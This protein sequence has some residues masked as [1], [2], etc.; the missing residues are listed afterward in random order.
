MKALL[1][2]LFF[3]LCGWSSNGE[4]S[5]CDQDLN[6]IVKARFAN[7]PGASGATDYVIQWMKHVMNDRKGF[8]EDSITLFLR[9]PR[10]ETLGELPFES[11]VSTQARGALK[12]AIGR[13]LESDVLKRAV[14]MERVTKAAEE[15]L[16]ERQGAKGERKAAQT[17]TSRLFVPTLEEAFD[18]YKD[19]FVRGAFISSTGD[20]Y[21]AGRTPFTR[22]F[23]DLAGDHWADVKF[24]QAA[25]TF[26]Y[27]ETRTGKPLIIYGVQNGLG[28]ADPRDGVLVASFDEKKI[29][30]V[31]NSLGDDFTSAN[32]QM[33]FERENGELA[34]MQV[35]SPKE[36]FVIM[37]FDRETTPL[38]KP[39]KT[40]W[41]NGYKLTRSRDGKRV[42]LSGKKLNNKA[43]F[44]ELTGEGK[45][46]WEAPRT[47]NEVGTDQVRMF[48]GREGNMYLVNQS[49]NEAYLY[50]I[51]KGR[52]FKLEVE[53]D[54][55]TNDSHHEQAL[56]HEGPAGKFFYLGGPLK[57]SRR[58]LQFLDVNKGEVKSFTAK[59]KN[60]DSFWSGQF[61]ENAEGKLFFISH[62]ENQIEDLEI[63]DLVAGAQ[64]TLNMSAFGIEGRHAVY[65][66]RDGE[67]FG[68]FSR[69]E[70]GKKMGIRRIKLYGF[71]K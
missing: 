24:Y 25:P 65:E 2:F 47:S 48:E 69:K 23:L 62:S 41:L 37:S 39:F 36:G 18:E 11:H 9:S 51:G 1:L 6:R 13:V 52:E 64:Y 15:A 32:A 40:P 12:Q 57:E 21:L 58:S 63:I 46:S 20:I 3:T 14:D 4:A 27:F 38:Q 56:F 19:L 49:E 22:G 10:L 33:I 16:R 7:A 54:N 53:K 31:M 59:M 45:V 34:L 70:A 50:D 43:A 60:N 30:D 42:Y 17:V 55:G 68:V 5:S 61:I 67:L 29:D 71:Q 28:A 8:S 66:F 26:E 44:Y 35:W